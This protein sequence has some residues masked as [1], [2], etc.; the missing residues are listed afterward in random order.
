MKT[1]STKPILILSLLAVIIISGCIST[2]VFR[3]YPTRA[4]VYI[5]GE[6][7]GRTPY[8]YSDRK[9][10]ASTTPVTFRKIGYNDLSINLSRDEKVDVGPFI[11]GLFLLVPFLWVTKYDSLHAYQLERD[12]SELV[13]SPA[14]SNL[15]ESSVKVYSNALIKN[16]SITVM[17]EDTS[18]AAIE[19]EKTE[20]IENDSLQYTEDY[21]G[22]KPQVKQ[23]PTYFGFG[24]GFCLPGSV[25]GLRY[26]FISSGNL[27]CSIS[28][29]SNIFKSDDVPADY[30]D[31][32]NRVF[33]PKD[34]I[35]SFAF[36]IVKEFSSPKKSRRYGFEFG[37]AWDIYR[38]AQFKLNPGYDPY[39]GPL[40]NLYEK[41]HS[42]ENI[43]GLLLR[44]KMEF[45]FSNSSGMELAFFTN[46][47]RIKP[48]IGFEVDLILGRMG[49]TK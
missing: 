37:P 18:Q 25:W 4:D 29:N 28:I 23:N 13:L 8:Y 44:V 15:A 30:Y 26:T 24:G 45:L 2:T 40:S 9:I 17:A 11:G 47:N 38:E 3:T 6:K 1:I 10:V 22:Q 20:Y 39:Y 43:L 41:S 5:S 42:R 14:V 21:S 27:G 16:D 33:A 35:N 7:K 12:S 36:S 32:G 46:I 19:P 31:D 48:I 49:Y 34:Y